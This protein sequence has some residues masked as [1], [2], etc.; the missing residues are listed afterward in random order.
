MA[1]AIY[2]SL[3]DRHV[4]VTGGGSGIGASI[5]EAFAKQGARVSFIDVAETD[6]RELEQAL[7][8]EKHAPKFY[9]CDLRDTAAIEAIFDDMIAA[10]GPLDALVNNAAND[11]RHRWDDVSAAYWDERMAVN[12]RHQFFCAQA[13]AKSMRANRRGSIINMGS[14]S[15]HLALPELT[16]YM[17][18]KAAIEGL[19]RGLARDLGAHGVRVNTVIP[20]AVRTPRQMKLWQSPDSE[21]ALL[22]QQCLHERIDPEHVAR[23]VL[24]LAS[25][26][27]A[28]CTGRDYFVDAGWF[29][30]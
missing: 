4:V 24:F 13:A 3:V 30:T 10:A 9:R 12:L 26:D 27:A 16:L 15:W 5:V 14:I 21:A 1:Y 19:T 11:D 2:P 17:T 25:D 22:A 29:G 6:A 23:M 28:R 8:N 18:A 20:G 7:A